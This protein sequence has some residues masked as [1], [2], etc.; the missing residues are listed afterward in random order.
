MA[1]LDVV[2]KKKSPLLW[3]LLALLVIAIIGYLIWNSSNQ[4][5]TAT[6]PAAYDTTVEGNS[7][8]LDTTGR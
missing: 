2:R 6:T 5:A 4:A 1:E 3:I 7:G 8:S